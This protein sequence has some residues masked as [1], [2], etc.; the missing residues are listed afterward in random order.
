MN[1][2][3]ILG[4]GDV[5][6]PLLIHDLGQAQ[7]VPAA[8]PRVSP[9]SESPER[10]LA[11]ANICGALSTEVYGGIAGFPSRDRVLQELSS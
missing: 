7:N 9:V 11:V 10:C 1:K 2:I 5:R 4:G 6:T 8:P 3:A